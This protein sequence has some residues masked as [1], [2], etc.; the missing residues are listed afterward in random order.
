VNAI[1]MLFGGIM[2]PAVGFILDVCAGR[3]SG[4]ATVYS[5]RHFTAAFAI[6]PI[7]MA[8]GL[9]AAL[10]VKESGEKHS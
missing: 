6:L 8:M 10:A 4:G 7:A 1:V 9:A 3:R 2:Q 5:L